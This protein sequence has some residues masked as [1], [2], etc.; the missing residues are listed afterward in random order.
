MDNSSASFCHTRSMTVI[1]IQ[2]EICEALIY[3]SNT[4]DFP[5]K[6]KIII[7]D[8]MQTFFSF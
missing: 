8:A 3:I 6:E 7:T 4:E 5:G 1:L 2:L